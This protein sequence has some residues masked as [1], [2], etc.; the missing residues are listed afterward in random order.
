MPSGA[1]PGDL[2]IRL[3]AR[4]IDGIIVG[5][6]AAILALLVSDSDSLILVSGLFSGILTFAYF[7]A[8]EVTQGRTLGKMILGLSVHGPGGAPRPSVQQSAIRNAFTLLSIIPIIGGILAL[9]A[10]IVIAVTINN[11][12]TKQ[13]KHDE[14][15]GGTQ[16]VKG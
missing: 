5:I 16:V 1:Q 2:W 13:G 10:Y 15:A 9:V 4:I 12:P 6:I 7:I 3:G 11:S 14:L 8:M